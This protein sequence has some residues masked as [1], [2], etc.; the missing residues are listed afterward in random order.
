MCTFFLSSLPEGHRRKHIKRLLSFKSPYLIIVD[1]ART[2]GWNAIT[3]A[4]ELILEQNKPGKPLH[5]VAPCPHDGPCP[6]ADT[7]DICGFSQRVTAPKFLRQTKHSK[8]GEEDKKYVYLVV[9][10]GERPVAE[11]N[12]DLSRVGRMGA[13]AKEQLQRDKNKLEGKS[14]LREVEG[15]KHGGGQVQMEMV[16]LSDVAEEDRIRK[17]DPPAPNMDVDGQ[18]LTDHLRGEA[19]SWSRLVAPPLKRSGH[20]IMDVCSSSG[21]LHTP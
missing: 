6:L 7:A 16:S 15:D 8:R 3:R 9:A 17:G 5:I 21:E 2:E 12:S 10:R 4:R 18:A 20:V 14:V 13:V 1:H 19:Y 11:E